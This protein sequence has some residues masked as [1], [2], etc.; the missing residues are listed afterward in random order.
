M[1]WLVLEGKGGDRSLA[2]Q[3]EIPAAGT[4]LCGRSSQADLMLSATAVSRRHAIFF[5]ES[6]R[7]WVRDAGSTNGT[8]LNGTR[9]DEPRPLADGDRVEVGVVLLVYRE[10][11]AAPPSRAPRGE[12]AP[13]TGGLLEDTRRWR[14]VT[15]IGRGGMGEVY[16]AEDRDLETR[17]AIKRLRRR[18]GGDPRLLER[19]H[20]R[21]AALGRTIEHPNVVRVLE[22]S[23]VGDDPVLL[24]APRRQ[25]AAVDAAGV[26]AHRPL[27]AVVPARCPVPVHDQ[28]L[29]PIEQIALA[30]EP[31]Q[32]Q[33]QLIERPLCLAP[34]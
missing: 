9:I 7:D 13:P 34:L 15:L 24:L 11:V 2:K 3:V 8:L 1:G 4:L 22:D 18:S 28:R 31:L 32:R 5:R 29:A 26:E 10:F 30:I 33:R 16:R 19:L 20:A 23:V 25:L 6:D 17:V 27:A 14:D 21:E 12:A